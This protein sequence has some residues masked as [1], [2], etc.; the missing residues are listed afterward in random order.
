PRSSEELRLFR[1]IDVGVAVVA[2]PVRDAGAGDRR[3]E[4]IGILR[5]EPVRHEAAVRMAGMADA[6]RIDW[7]A[8]EHVV[9]PRDDVLAVPVAPRAPRRPFERVAVP[10]G[11]PEVRVEHEVAVG[12]EE[13]FLEIEAVAGRRMRTAVARYDQRI[14]SLRGVVTVREHQ[15]AFDWRAVLARPLQPIRFA[16]R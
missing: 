8:F 4:S 16:Q 14:G 12:G 7:I 13:L 3:G 10:R 1:A 5:D 2:R 9:D 6:L 11:A 15:P